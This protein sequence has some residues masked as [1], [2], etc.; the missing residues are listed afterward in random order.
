MQVILGVIFHFRGL[1]PEVLYS[2]KKVRM[3]LGE[4]LDYRGLFFVAY[5]SATGNLADYTV[6]LKS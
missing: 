1:H 5:R 4:L 2:H 3:V 6:S